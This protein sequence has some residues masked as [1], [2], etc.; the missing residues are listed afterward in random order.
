MNGRVHVSILLHTNG[1]DGRTTEIILK[2]IDLWKRNGGQIDTYAPMLAASNGAE[3]WSVGDNKYACKDTIALWHIGEPTFEMT[4][5]NMALLEERVEKELEEEE[6]EEEDPDEKYREKLKK[7]FKAAKDC[8]EKE[9][10][11]HAIEHHPN[12]EFTLTGEELDQMGLVTNLFDSWIE[13]ERYLEVRSGFEI[14]GKADLRDLNEFC[15]D[16]GLK[17]LLSL[18]MSRNAPEE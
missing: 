11:L 18:A 2:S 4:E 15:R 12:A 6:K 14:H 9:R 3:I 7:Q 17:Y 16:M 10:T 1:G 13:M 8:E 5:G